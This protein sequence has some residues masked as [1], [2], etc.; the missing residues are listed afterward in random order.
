MNL[1]PPIVVLITV[2]IIALSAFFV[3]AEF[4]LL[5]AKRHRLEDQALRSRSALAALRNASELTVL[6]AGSQLGITVSALALG[7]ITKPAVHDW[8]MPAF[9]GFGIP[10]VTADV[11]AFI[12][13][14]FVVTFLHL[15]IGEMAP[16]SWAI[17]HPELSATALAI[18]MRGFLFVSR[19]LLIALNNTANWLLKR[20][21]VDPVNSVSAA[22]NTDSLKQLVQH[23]VHTGA[24][25]IEYSVRVAAALTMQSTPIKTLVPFGTPISMVSTSATVGQV[26]EASETSGH[27]RII[28]GD[29]NG[30]ESGGIVEPRLVGVVHVRDTLT[31]S[32]HMPIRRLIRPILRLPA[33]QSIYESL[34]HMRRTSSHIAVVMEEGKVVGL[35]TLSDVIRGLVQR[36]DSLTLIENDISNAQQESH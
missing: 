23:S 5:A 4:A 26:R 30:H 14:L 32:E 31:S 3:A 34:A 18:P 24:L 27:H 17:A 13:A 20:V 21:G 6:L 12:L 15:V 22:Q 36:D 16:K 28:V 10:A 2:V 19:P 33:E 8:L 9:E 11:V 29:Q 25:D 1:S 35:V 7:A